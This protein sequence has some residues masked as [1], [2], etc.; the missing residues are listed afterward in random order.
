VRKSQPK[1]ISL[2]G[3]KPKEEFK[4]GGE[5]RNAPEGKGNGRRTA[6]LCRVHPVLCLMRFLKDIPFI[7]YVD[8]S[9]A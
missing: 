4:A 8:E 6:G 9:K 5:I 7:R 1:G 3:R 2:L